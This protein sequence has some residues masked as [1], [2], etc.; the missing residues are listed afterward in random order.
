MTSKTKTS[1]PEENKAIGAVLIELAGKAREVREIWAEL[2]GDGDFHLRFHGGDDG[3]VIRLD[4][5][6]RT[7]PLS[8]GPVRHLGQERPQRRAG[9]HRHDGTG[10]GAD[11]PRSVVPRNS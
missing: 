7:R 8:R 11:V 10:H 4:F 9:D 5:L 3:K 1:D 6:G 2:Y